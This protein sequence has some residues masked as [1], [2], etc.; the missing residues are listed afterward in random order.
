MKFYAD[1]PLRFFLQFLSD[2]L[3][4]AWIAGW[5]WA[6]VSLHETL[7]GLARPGELMEDAGGGLSAHM[8]EAAERAGEI[9]LIGDTLSEPFTSVGTS[10]EAL[11]EAGQRFQETVADLALVVAL[12]TA[13]IPLLFVLA[14]WLPLR[15]RW[16]VR[17]G[18]A[19][20]LRAMSPEARGELLALRALGSVP[21]GRLLKIHSDPVG[22]WRTG[23]ARTIA[24]LAD[25]ELRRL[26]LRP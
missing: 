8:G 13:V 17:A 26:G 2:T 24:R 11:S 1:R 21:P 3:A 10:G 23:D 5:V 9:P 18:G 15:A 12:L 20:R 7:S 25:L 14:T 6:A 22:A 19:R 4:L 16:V